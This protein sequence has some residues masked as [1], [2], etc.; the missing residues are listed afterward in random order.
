MA[1]KVALT[2]DLH[3]GLTSEKSIRKVLRSINKYGPDIYINAGDNCGGYNCAVSVAS[4]CRFESEEL[5]E[6]VV[7]AH[8][9]GNHDLWLGTK[10]R[11]NVW[12]PSLA[13]WSEAQAKIRNTFKTN[14]VHF[15]DE[16][17]V[18][19]I[20]GWALVGHSGWYGGTK[21]PSTNDFNY[22]PI[23]IEG[24]THRFLHRRFY[25]SIFR[26]ADSLTEKDKRRACVTHFPLVIQEAS[27]DFAGDVCVGNVLREDFGVTKFFNGHFHER[28][29][30]PLR[31]EAGSDYY[32]PRWLAVELETDE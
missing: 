17:G 10:R 13:A 23:G 26:Q 21:M 6:G 19:R 28:H 4:V 15:F 31:Y 27:N 32:K 3:L 16:D 12:R 20:N 11:G 2:S 1:F 18:L 24:D 29:E 30:G 9:L 22:L 25:T 14:G 5:G 8:V 7:K